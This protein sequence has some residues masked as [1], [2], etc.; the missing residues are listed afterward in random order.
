MEHTLRPPEKIG[1]LLGLISQ[2][3]DY[4]LKERGPSANGVFWKN[5]EGQMLRHEILLQIIEPKDLS[6]G[7][8]IND[9][10]CGYGALFEMLKTSP[11]MNG[12]QYFG[13]D[14]SAEMIDAAHMRNHE[15]CA[16]FTLGAMAAQ[17]ADYSFA[18]GTFNM[19]MGAD[20]MLWRDY[21]FSTLQR[22]W[23]N[24]EKGMAFNLL[25]SKPSEHLLNLYYAD[26]DEVMEFARTLSP[27]VE[28][29]DDYPLDEWTIFVRREAV[30]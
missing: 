21:V 23:E 13:N 10:G 3:Y 2:V 14:I 18:S 8:T 19:F 28:V 27:H 6:G 4:R 26:F 16:T 22:L 29:V 1:D 9:L 24:T 17:S 7:I 12:S 20:R 25:D 11:I 15:P 30:T 5:A